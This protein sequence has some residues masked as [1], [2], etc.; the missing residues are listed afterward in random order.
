VIA[1]EFS[2]A[3]PAS[4]AEAVELLAADPGGTRLIGGGT[5]LVPEL[6]RGVSAPRQVI[7][8]RRAGLGEIRAG[9]GT[10]HVGATCSYAALAG[11]DV[12]ADSL[13]LLRTMA[14]GITGGRQIQNQGTIG[15]SVAAARP[16]SDAPA[17]VVALGA[18]AIVAGPGGE[19]RVPARDLFAGAMQTT[20]DD[21]EILVGFDI[22]AAPDASWGYHKL[23][24]AA[25][26]WP[27]ATAAALIGPASASLVLGGVAATP[28][29]VDIDD[30]L[31]GAALDDERIALAADRAGDAVIEPWADELA[32]GEYRAAVA[33]PVA[34]RAL[35][36]AARG[37]KA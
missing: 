5:W 2:Y 9:N 8:L 15:G 14:E 30:L 21:G 27:I 23:K 34:R 33:A 25:G 26:S 28:L 3:A 20:L 7:D 31:A 16:Q 13:P 10:I 6:N 11:S 22:P 18:T 37:G 17:T 1:T 4:L 36:M 32:P 19:R 24:R 29:V 12:V 35:R